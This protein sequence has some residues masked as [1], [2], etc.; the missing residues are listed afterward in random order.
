MELSVRS[1]YDREGK[2]KYLSR[3]EG[4][5]FLEQTVRLPKRDALF[6]L[7]LYYTGCRI[8]EALNLR[9]C[10]LDRELNTV[11]IR[12]LKKRGRKE[13]RRIPLPEFLSHE[14]MATAEPGSEQR[15]WMFSRTTGWR[16][17]KRVMK[18]AA[19]SGVQATTKGLRHGFG[20]RG[21][22]GQI[23]LSLIQHWMGHADATTT[24]IYLAVQDEEERALIQKTW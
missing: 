12:S 7:T 23:P 13:I 3:T 22:M 20:V 1:A 9:G 4:Q 21:A 18:G 24:A 14:L 5:K 15:I 8:S 2:R 16:M 17:I 6:C 11:L 19:I 10:D